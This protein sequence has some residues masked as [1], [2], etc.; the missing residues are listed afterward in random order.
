MCVS[1]YNMCHTSLVR[2]VVL[3]SNSYNV[4]QN[5]KRR[6]LC[7]GARYPASAVG[8][9]FIAVSY[10]LIRGAI[11]VAWWLETCNLSEFQWILIVGD[12]YIYIYIYTQVPRAEVVFVSFYPLVPRYALA[13]TSIQLSQGWEEHCGSNSRM[14]CRPPFLHI[15]TAL[16]K[17]TGLKIGIFT[18]LYTIAAIVVVVSLNI[19]KN[20]HYYT[21]SGW[22]RVGCLSVEPVSKLCHHRRNLCTLFLTLLHPALP[23]LIW[24]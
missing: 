10:N 17:I 16:Q 13:L 2:S 23:D 4:S 14:T 18:C 3:Y 12:T 21:V 9:T 5:D 1:T 15:M 11:P 6:A 22:V 20:Q 19:L 24:R 8:L 7:L